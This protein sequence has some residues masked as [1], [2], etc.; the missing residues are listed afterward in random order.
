MAT[1]DMHRKFGKVWHVVFKICEQT[2]KQTTH[3]VRNV[4]LSLE[5][6]ST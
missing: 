3:S 2:Y 1:V 5:R 6:Y 4:H